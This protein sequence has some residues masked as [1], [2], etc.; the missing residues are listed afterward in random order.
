MSNEKTHTSVIEKEVLRETIKG[1]F[2]ERLRHS[3]GEISQTE[4]AAICGTS[5][6]MISRW[7]QGQCL[8][9]T[10]NLYLMAKNKDLS[11]DWL[12]TGREPTASLNAWPE[13]EETLTILRDVLEVIRSNTI[14]ADSLKMNIRS[15]LQA[16]RIE[17]K[18]EE[19]LRKLEEALADRNHPQ[20]PE[21]EPE[22]V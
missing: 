19:R 3:R 1:G 18:Y 17:A 22:A 2:T 8:P 11:V 15:F 5:Q 7:E 6:Q 16:V 4:F 10:E 20:I 13:D 21:V 14:H 12:L 9:S